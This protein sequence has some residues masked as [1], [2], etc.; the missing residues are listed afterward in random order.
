MGEEEKK[1]E[2]IVNQKR[3]LTDDIC[4]IRNEIKKLKRENGKGN[5][6]VYDNIGGRSERHDMV[7]CNIFYIRMYKC[8]LLGLISHELF[9]FVF[10]LIVLVVILSRICVKKKGQEVIMQESMW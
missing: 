3:K 8:F 5:Q 6:T 1:Y 4:G 7:K 10:Q 2:R 9:T